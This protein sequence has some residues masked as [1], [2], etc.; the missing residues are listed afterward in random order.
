MTHRDP[1]PPRPAPETLARLQEL[2]KHDYDAV[3]RERILAAIGIRVNKPADD[4]QSDEPIVEPEH[5]TAQ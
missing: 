3:P 5:I 1:V 4:L 2:T